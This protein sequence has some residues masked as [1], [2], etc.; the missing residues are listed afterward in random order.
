MNVKLIRNISQTKY[1]EIEIMVCIKVFLFKF[2]SD[3][4]ILIYF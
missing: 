1:C 4:L 2:M 3:Y